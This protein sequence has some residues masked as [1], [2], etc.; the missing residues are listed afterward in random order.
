MDS[1]EIIVPNGAVPGTSLSITNPSDGSKSTILVPQGVNPGQKITVQIPRAQVTVIAQPQPQSNSVVV[2]VQTNPGSMTVA[3][4]PVQTQSGSGTI[5]Q[6]PLNKLPQDHQQTHAVRPTPVIVGAPNNAIVVNADT[7]PQNYVQAQVA[8]VVP[9]PT[10]AQVING[11]SNTPD[12]ERTCCHY[13]TWAM[14]ILSVIF[15]LIA[16][17]LL[18]AIFVSA[19]H[20]L[21]DSSGSYQGLDLYSYHCVYTVIMVVYGGG[22]FYFWW[23]VAVILN[24]VAGATIAC[25]ACRYR[26]QRKPQYTINPTYRVCGW[27]WYGLNV[28]AQK[29]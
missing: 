6:A 10:Q 20:C 19:G 29:K 9:N 15:A 14:G 25:V 11:N 1:I 3:A 5:V 26:N 8:T 23:V 7:V 13:C 2:P 27:V 21:F 28:C 4:V 24:I 16:L 17:G 18:I 22:A 12:I